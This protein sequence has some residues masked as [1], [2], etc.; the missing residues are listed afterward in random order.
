MSF[1]K[2]KNQ[3]LKRFP[4][5]QESIWTIFYFLSEIAKIF[6]KTLPLQNILLVSRAT[7][8]F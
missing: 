8:S 6:K 1:E 5:S 2:V 3:Y 4:E 7:A